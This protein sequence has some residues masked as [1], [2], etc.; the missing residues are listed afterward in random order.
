MHI[1]E[2]N[3]EC[4]KLSMNKGGGRFSNIVPPEI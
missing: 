4:S 3:T 1:F 2:Y